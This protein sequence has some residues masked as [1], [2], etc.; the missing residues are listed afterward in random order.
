MPHQR[1]ISVIG[2]GYVGLTIAHAFGRQNPVVGYDKSPE[3]INDLINYYDKNHELSKEDLDS[4]KIEYTTDPSDIKKAD[5]HICAVLTPINKDKIPDL[6]ILLEA[7]E[8]IAKN[9]KKGDIVVYESTVYPGATEE[10]CIPLLE[11]VSGMKCGLDFNVGYSPERINPSDKEHV[12]DNIIKIVSATNK[13]TLDVIAD[14]YKSVISAGVFPVSTIKVA[15]ATKVIENT[16]RDLNISLMNEVALILHHLGMDSTEVIS[17]LKTKWNH[18]SFTPGLVGGHCIGINS[19][20]LTYKAESMG[21]H[22]Q[23]IQAGRRTND[24]IPKFLAETAIKLL[25]HLDKPVHKAKIVIMGLAY[26]ENCPDLAD[27]RVPEIIQ[28][29][30]PYDVNV[31]VHDPYV[32][33]NLAQ[34]MYGIDLVKWESLKN[35]D[36]MI[37]TAGHDAFANTTVQQFLS[38]FNKKGLII[39]V[40]NVLKDHDFQDTGVTVWKL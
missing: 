17:A 13:E 21:Y 1:K 14:V 29:L 18:L 36:A 31:L 33:P 39:D 6:S 11:K 22:P 8:M 34:R 27:S 15:E 7:T 26:K 4:T 16:Q 25:I 32:D 28:N 9:L 35:V 37:I 2:L 5:F 24:Y 10:K 20:Y 3:R 30:L 40:K 19:Y 38:V 12:F 23:V